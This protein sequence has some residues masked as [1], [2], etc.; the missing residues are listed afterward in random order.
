VLVVLGVADALLVQRQP[1][2]EV[3][4]A[5]RHFAKFVVVLQVLN[6]GFD[7]RRVV[8]HVFHQLG[9][10][11]EDAFDN[12]VLRGLLRVGRYRRRRVFL[13]LVLIAGE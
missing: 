12:F 7:D 2:E 13:L 5:R 9:F 8:V 4:V 11:V 6:V 3:G 10:L 1:A